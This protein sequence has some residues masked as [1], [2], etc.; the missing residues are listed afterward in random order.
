MKPE[1]IEA[2]ERLVAKYIYQNHPVTTEVKSLAKAVEDG[3]LAFFEEKYGDEVR[4]IQIGDVSMELCGGTHCSRTAEI[5]CMKILGES[6]IAAGIRRIEAATGY[7]AYEYLAEHDKCLRRISQVLRAAPEE[8]VS[9]I[10]KLLEA[11]RNLAKEIEDR[12]RAGLMERGGDL[13]KRAENINGVPVLLTN[14]GEMSPKDLAAIVDDIK[15]RAKSGIVVLAGIFA[16]KANLICQVSPDLTDRVDAGKLVRETALVIG[17]SG[18]GKPERAQA[19]G[20]DPSKLD[21]A[22]DAARTIITKAL[23]KP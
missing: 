6:S 19:G 1:E 17:G 16:E 8:T 9:R 14:M 15:G 13:W 12:N 23:A 21:A 10:E 20:R 4:V 2:A 7:D 22:L 18:G 3:A 5:G 11:N